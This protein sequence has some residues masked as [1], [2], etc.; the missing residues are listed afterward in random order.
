MS[1][2]FEYGARFEILRQG[3]EDSMPT[4]QALVTWPD[5]GRAQFDVRVRADGEFQLEETEGTHAEEWMR[6]RLVKMIRTFV[7]TS[8]R[9]GKWP[10]RLS[11]WKE[12][13]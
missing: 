12:K 13:P 7:K 4:Y 1:G 11:V 10:R 6:E 2:R 9:S 8:Q 3:M 5:E